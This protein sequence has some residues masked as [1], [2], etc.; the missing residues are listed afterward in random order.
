MAAL[1]RFH[2]TY[3]NDR[4]EYMYYNM[5]VYVCRCGPC[6]TVAPKFIDLSRK[7]PDVL[8]LKVDVDICRVSDNVR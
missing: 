7:Y 6:K 1:D 5:C 4:H 3:Y 8:F 2:C